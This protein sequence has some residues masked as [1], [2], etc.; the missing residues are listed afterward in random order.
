MSS[1][2]QAAS[3][4][5]IVQLN[6]RHHGPF[7]EDS[8]PISAI[9]LR[10]YY[11]L[12]RAARLWRVSTADLVRSGYPKDDYDELWRW[13]TKHPRRNGNL[14]SR[15]SSIAWDLAEGYWSDPDNQQVVIMEGHLEWSS[16]DRG[17]FKLI[18]HP[19]KL[20]KGCRFFRRFTSDRFLAVTFPFL[21]E[22]CKCEDLQKQVARW[23][24]EGDQYI[25]G[26][27]WKAFHIDERK[28]GYRV[29]FFA[30]AGVDFQAAQ[31]P[32]SPRLEKAHEHTPMSVDK[33]FQWMIPLQQNNTQEDCKL[34]FRIRLGLS[35]TYATAHIKP[36]EVIMVPDRVRGREV[37]NDGCSRISMALAEKI[38]IALGTEEP[39]PSCFQAR[40]G[41]AKG[42]WIVEPVDSSNHSDKS[43][44]IEISA[45]QLKF[46]PGSGCVNGCL[47]PELQ[48]FEVVDW[49][50]PLRTSKLSTQLITILEDRGVHRSTFE[51][52]IQRDLRCVSGLI[53]AVRD[54]DRHL[55][56][57]LLRTVTNVADC[58]ATDGWPN[59]DSGQAITLLE[60]GFEPRTCSYL[61]ECIRRC[62]KYYLD[63]Y[64]RKLHISVPC[65]TTAYCVADPYG[66]LE[67]NEVHLMFSH[68]WNV[69]GFNDIALVDIDVLIGR[70]PALASTDIQKRRAVYRAELRHLVD[71]IVFPTKGTSPLAKLLSGGDYD[72]DRVWVCWERNIIREF[73]NSSAPSDTRSDKRLHLK[74]CGELLIGGSIES[75]FWTKM[76]NFYL[77]RSPI[78]ICTK[79]HES[80]SASGGV[81][82]EKT[83]YITALLR[84]LHEGKKSGVELGTNGLR[85]LQNQIGNRNFSVNNGIVKYLSEL[86][87]TETD[88]MLRQFH[89]GHLS[90]AERHYDHDILGFWKSVKE[91]AEIEKQSGRPLLLDGLE[92]LG[93]N[94]KYIR[95]TIW[96]KYRPHDGRE[97]FIS[98]AQEASQA[99][100]ELMPP[101]ID[102]PLGHTWNNSKY[103]WDRLRAAA[104][105]T[106]NLD[107][108]FPWFTVGWSL[109]RI[110]TP[111]TLVHPMQPDIFLYFRFSS[112]R[113]WKHHESF[114]NEQDDNVAV[115]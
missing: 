33:L 17:H 84:I 5:E 45:S 11:E 3:K 42:M 55:C 107:G 2:V 52:L 44:W 82:S 54:N 14:P 28:E 102:H 37:M 96:R 83:K 104:V 81:S 71:V 41:G 39:P 65:S 8:P 68:R 27:K 94:I 35:R 106:H 105:Y 60:A 63:R 49:S 66:I 61:T 73:E 20:E 9:S 109:C 91:R 36:T 58:S 108:K 78:G 24:S 57:M 72:G 10:L 77:E 51:S 25:L 15:S 47:D 26:R 92:N 12:E 22:H 29:M 99:I 89:Q 114:D 23:L 112:N 95:M 32:I 48:Q 86:A 101:R 31:F 97:G 93:R 113:F 87:T 46:N 88:L 38:Q 40:I 90:S 16:C 34:F 76:F 103:E 69:E 13:L 80:F 111:P 64:T 21:S 19:L 43:H 1:T 18:L 50:R 4:Q 62:V 100:Q 56:L 67:E 59:T 98:I 6:L 70:H 7:R 75:Q 85:Y 30:T 53:A 74:K 115:F 110:K 79:W